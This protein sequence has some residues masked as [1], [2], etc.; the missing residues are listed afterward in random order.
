[1]ALIS[2]E[3]RRD[4]YALPFESI[5]SSTFEEFNTHAKNVWHFVARPGLNIIGI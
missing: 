5:L 1:M 2:N 3:E 4:S